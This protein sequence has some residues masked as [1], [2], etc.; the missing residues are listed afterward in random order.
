MMMALG[1]SMQR[2]LLAA[3][4]IGTSLA[5]VARAESLLGLT[6]ENTLL[7]FDSAAPGTILDTVSVTGLQTNEVLLGIDQRPRMDGLD[8]AL[9]RI[10][11]IGSGN[12]LYRINPNTGA[13]T[14][15]LTP[16]APPFALSGVEF[17]FDFN[18]TV[19]RIRVVSNADQNIRLN[20]LTGG[21]AATDLPLKY[22][23]MAPIDVNSGQNPNVV[24]SAYTNNVDGAAT[25]VLYGIDSDLDIL[26][27]QT[28]PNDGI[29]N[30][31]GSLGFDT[32]HL[33]AFDVSGVSA[34]AY[35]S[36]TAP[37][38][39]R[40]QLALINLSSGAATTV[41]TIGGLDT[42]RGLTVIPEPTTVMLLALASLAAVRSR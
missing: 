9:G 3:T 20:P 2:G 6:T 42:L 33:T 31:I 26:V 41:G 4:L 17:G 24:A 1:T 28:P 22:R 29:L 5:A 32:T 19:D 25:T 15:V 11:A 39:V 27:T 18:P 23:D 21:S 37:G 35:A 12:N 14:L 30:T 16:G 13:A 7:R 8:G 34:V 36:L 38:D 40:S 10:F